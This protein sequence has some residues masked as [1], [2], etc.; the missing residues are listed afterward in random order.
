LVLFDRSSG[1]ARR[2]D[3]CMCVGRHVTSSVN[4]DCTNAN[5]LLLEHSEA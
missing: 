1:H 5:A 4:R 2:E 3:T